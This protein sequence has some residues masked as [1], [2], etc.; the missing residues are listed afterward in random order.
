MATIDHVTLEVADHEAAESFYSATFGGRVPLRLRAS[1][2]ASTG[3]RGFTLSLVVPQP[4]DVD[5][6]MDDALAA[7]A[8]VLKPA[9]KSL[10]GYGGA[11]QAPDG[12]VWT[13]ASAR[14]KGTGD[15]TGQVQ[16]VVLQLGVADVPASTAFY[17]ERG[18]PVAKR[19]GRRYVEL[20]TGPVTLTLNKRAALAKAAGVPA[21]GTGS[22]RLTVGSAAGPF[23]YPDGFVWESESA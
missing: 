22:H 18:I 3:F 2:T 13:L 9:E 15:A 19:Y 10:W 21:D 17:V 11:V 1:G 6:L 16:D 7:G 14:K 20:D 12:T 23:T 5:V 8:T 4:A